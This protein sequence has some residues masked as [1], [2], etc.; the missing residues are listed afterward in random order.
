MNETQKENTQ[1]ATVVNRKYKSTVFTMIFSEKEKLLELY[2]A[3]TGKNYKDP[4]ALTINTIKGAVYMM[5]NN[6]I[7]FIIDSR[8]SLYEHQSTYNPNMPL[9]LYLYFSE[10]LADFTK[11]MNLYGSTLIH[12]PT[13]RFV[14]FYNGVDDRPDYERHCISEAFKIKEEETML[15]LKVDVYNVNIGHNREMMEACK[16]LA[17]YAEYVSR[18][19]KYAAELPTTELAVDRAIDECIK[20]GILREFLQTQ[21][22]EAKVMSIYEYDQEAHMRMEREEWFEKG[23]EAAAERVKEAEAKAEQAEAKAE[24]AEAEKKEAEAEIARL[25]EEISRLTNC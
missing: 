17:E 20:E 13:P 6:D 7:S 9:R 19:R 21:R 4:E 5:Y 15:E 16:T 22:A 14:V 18:V 3:V 23:Q 11:N 2:N 25:K 8:I 1:M 24:K 12:I 10:L